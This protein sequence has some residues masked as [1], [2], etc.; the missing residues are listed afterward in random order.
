MKTTG[1]KIEKLIVEI[2]GLSIAGIA[3]I[4]AIVLIIIALTSCATIPVQ[5]DDTYQQGA[6]YEQV[7][8]STWIR[9]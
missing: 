7:N 4:A 9:L 8:D 1:E 5:Y 6:L 2:I 3:V